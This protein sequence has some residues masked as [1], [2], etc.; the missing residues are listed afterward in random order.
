VL[1]HD[2]AAGAG[3][4]R[5]AAAE[6]PVDLAGPVGRS[7]ATWNA[8]G[9]DAGVNSGVTLA[10]SRPSCGAWSRTRKLSGIHEAP[11][12]STTW[13]LVRYSSRHRASA[14]AFDSKETSSTT[15]KPSRRSRTVFR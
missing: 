6:R 13:G 10:G 14:S 2:Q 15:S 4:G 8:A 9:T 3:S 12:F 11:V 1:Q 5:A 7:R